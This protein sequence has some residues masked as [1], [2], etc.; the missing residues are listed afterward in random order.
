MR[1]HLA[2]ALSSLPLG[3]LVLVGCQDEPGLAAVRIVSTTWNGWDAD[4]EPASTTLTLA[5]AEGEQ[6]VAGCGVTL[7]VADVGRDRAVVRSDEALA[8]VNASGGTD[9]RD[10]RDDWEVEAGEVVEMATAT[11]D[12]GCT[13]EL[14]VG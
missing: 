11:M 14:S 10:T 1:P 13:F 7:T 6:G 4:H 2:A 3:L 9:L 5:P 12:G 8:P